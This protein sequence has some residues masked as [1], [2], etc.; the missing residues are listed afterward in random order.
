MKIYFYKAGSGLGR[1]FELIE[2][3]WEWKEINSKYFRV[4]GNIDN[5]YGIVGDKYLYLSQINSVFER[6]DYIF[7]SF[8]KLKRRELNELI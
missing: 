5:V 2:E 7:F 3:E 4:S 6:N 8:R 1:D